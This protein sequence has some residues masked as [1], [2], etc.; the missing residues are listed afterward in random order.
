MAEIV[1]CRNVRAPRPDAVAPFFPLPSQCILY[2]KNE[3][4]PEEEEGGAVRYG[5]KNKEKHSPP[6]PIT[7]AQQSKRKTVPKYIILYT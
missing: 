4:L 3:R 7:A 1:S 5:N 6:S 2:Y